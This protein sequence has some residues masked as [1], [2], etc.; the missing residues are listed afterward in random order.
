MNTVIRV[1]SSDDYEATHEANERELG[2][3]KLIGH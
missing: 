1:S 2:L 3:G